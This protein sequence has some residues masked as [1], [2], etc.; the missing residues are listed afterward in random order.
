MSNKKPLSSEKKD[1]IIAQLKGELYQYHQ[2]QI[3]FGSLNNQLSRLENAYSLG[4]EELQKIQ[5]V[6]RAQTEVDLNEIKQLRSELDYLQEQLHQRLPNNNPQLLELAQI[7]QNELALLKKETN[8]IMLQKDQLQNERE[9]LETTMRDMIE[10]KN[11]L[12]KENQ[13]LEKEY[14]KYFKQ[15]KELEQTRQDLEFEISKKEKVVLQ[16]KKMIDIFNKEQKQKGDYLQQMQMK[17]EIQQQQTGQLDDQYQQLNENLEAVTNEQKLINNQLN[18][19]QLEA[20]E[21]QLENI[22][23]DKNIKQLESVIDTFFNQVDEENLKKMNLVEDQKFLN[24]EMNRALDL[25]NQ[26]SSIKQ[27]LCEEIRTFISE[28]EQISH[29]VNRKNKQIKLIQ[30]A[31]QQI[32]DSQSNNLN[33]I[34]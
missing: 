9:Q 12:E 4:Q 28:D 18:Q 32:E 29:I 8:E 34:I 23:L 10:T 14:D 2:R 21:T 5:K 27:D 26:L 17:Q 15:N 31:E 11:S 24:V 13:L 33:N 7:R 30:Y 1:G 6:G 3:D 25:I 16:Q 19:C 20:K 22:N